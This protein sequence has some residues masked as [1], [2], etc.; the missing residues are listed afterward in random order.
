MGIK[1]LKLFCLL[2]S[3]LVSVIGYIF[4]FIRKETISQ[5]NVIEYNYK[6]I[7]LQT[8]KLRCRFFC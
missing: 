6:N 5:R 1:L 3:L 8:V 4:V 7:N 2:S